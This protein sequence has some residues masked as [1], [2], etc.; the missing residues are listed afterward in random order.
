MPRDRRQEDDKGLSARLF[1]G[2]GVV[3][4]PEECCSPPRR[5]ARRI[6]ASSG[7][8]LLEVLRWLK[9]DAAREIKARPV[10]T[11]SKARPIICKEPKD[12]YC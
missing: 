5:R 4:G 8:I 10:I 12:G 7:F 1:G 9:V 2:W 3:L 6:I 11:E